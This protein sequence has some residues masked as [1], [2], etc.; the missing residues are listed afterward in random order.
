VSYS[1]V[2]NL[3][4]TKEFYLLLRTIFYPKMLPKFISSFSNQKE[5]MALALALRTKRGQAAL[6]KFVERCNRNNRVFDRDVVLLTNAVNQVLHDIE[7]VAL[8]VTSAQFEAQ[9]DSSSF[10]MPFGKIVSR[11]YSFS[12]R[13]R[14]FI[15]GAIYTGGGFSELERSLFPPKCYKKSLDDL[16]HP[17]ELNRHYYPEVYPS[18]PKLY[19]S[20]QTVVPLQLEK[21]FEQ[22]IRPSL[23]DSLPT[24]VKVNTQQKSTKKD[25]TVESFSQHEILGEGDPGSPKLKECL[26]LREQLNG[27]NNS[28]ECTPRIFSSNVG[29]RSCHSTPEGSLTL[30]PL[31]GQLQNV[32]LDNEASSSDSGNPSNFGN[33]AN[34]HSWHTN[35]S[36]YSDSMSHSSLS[37]SP[38]LTPKLHLGAVAHSLTSPSLTVAQPIEE[39]HQPTPSLSPQSERPS[40][41]SS[42]RSEGDKFP[43]PGQDELSSSLESLVFCRSPSPT[44]SFHSS[45]S[46]HSSDNEWLAAARPTAAAET[47]PVSALFVGNTHPPS[48]LYLR[49]KGQE[50]ISPE[51]EHTSAEPAVISTDTSSLP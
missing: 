29:P 35:Y 46:S 41:P 34:S 22:A 51:S 8:T 49:S 39:T 42:H 27:V 18:S 37:L 31:A 9:V 38:P 50:P 30:S 16:A 28:L 11:N 19:T 43:L 20:S 15:R 1:T 4:E 25:K 47:E 33:S 32:P 24:L 48:H 45:I 44:D 10:E 36:P 5:I 6:A 17:E 13:R 40:T 26:D 2:L 23:L 7:H 14:S 3:V 12:Q 21:P